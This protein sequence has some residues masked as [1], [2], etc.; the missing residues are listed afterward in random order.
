MRGHKEHIT[1]K[2][3][4]NPPPSAISSTEIKNLSKKNWVR[5][6]KTWRGLKLLIKFLCFALLVVLRIRQ[7]A[8]ECWGVLTVIR[9]MPAPAISNQIEEE[10]STLPQV[11]TVI[12]GRPRQYIL[13][14]RAEF[15]ISP[16]TQKYQKS[17][18]AL[19]FII[20]K[21]LSLYLVLWT[22]RPV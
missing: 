20:V 1:I 14:T 18:M 4:I 6:R 7:D 3:V 2:T 11:H 21:P 22:H 8:L 5:T 12:R 10:V 15:L 16:G 17:P 9:W 19:S 13:D